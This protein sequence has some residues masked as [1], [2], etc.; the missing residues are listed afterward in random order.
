LVIKIF[1]PTIGIP[2]WINLSK[3]YT[4]PLFK[5]FLQNAI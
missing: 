2:L 1:E 5:I 4:I 3:T